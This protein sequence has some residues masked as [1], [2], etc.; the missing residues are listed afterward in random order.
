MRR[1][2]YLSVK[3]EPKQVS[4]Q[5]KQYI[6]FETKILICTQSKPA[7]NILIVR[8]FITNIL[9]TLFPLMYYADD[10][11]NSYLLRARYLINSLILIVPLGVCSERE[12]TVAQSKL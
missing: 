8:E 10:I 4:F 5:E 2:E 1:I 11:G 6:S 7:T 3:I 9:S 12:H